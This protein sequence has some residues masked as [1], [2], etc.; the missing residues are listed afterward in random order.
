MSKPEKSLRQ[1]LLDAR[2]DIER[3]IEILQAGPSFSYRGGGNP[4]FEPVIADLTATLKEIED[5]L[6]ELGENG[7]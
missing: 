4:Q 7:A 5:S 2:A 3:Q 6:A 1:Q